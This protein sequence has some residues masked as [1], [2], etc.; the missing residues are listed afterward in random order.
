MAYANIF[1]H[2]TVVVTLS[3]P[4]QVKN[5]SSHPLITSMLKAINLKKQASMI[6]KSQI[7]NIQDLLLWLESH[8]PDKRRIFQVSRHVALLL[9]LASGRRI[10]DLTLLSICTDSCVITETS[11]TF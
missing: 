5:L 8:L 7:W 9:L 3:D 6:P 10:Q 4:E 11:V 1:V 2:K